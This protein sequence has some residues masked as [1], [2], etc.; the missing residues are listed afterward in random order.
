MHARPKSEPGVEDL[1][2]GS[3]LLQVVRLVATPPCAALATEDSPAYSAPALRRAFSPDSMQQLLLAQSLV[4]AVLPLALRKQPRVHYGLLDS[5][6]GE[7]LTRRL[8][9]VPFLGKDAPSP[10]SEFSHPDVRTVM[11]CLAYVRLRCAHA[12]LQ[13]Q[14]SAQVP[15][16]CASDCGWLHS[17]V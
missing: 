17:R 10:S 1:P 6:E 13:L 11:T 7:T 15:H 5:V 3:P 4:A 16:R 9:A 12:V 8:L 14:R 2:I